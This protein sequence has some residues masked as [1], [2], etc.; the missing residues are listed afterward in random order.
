M[1]R[2][3]VTGIASLA[4]LFSHPV[5]SMNLDQMLVVADSDGNGAFVMANN[6]EQSY[7]I[8]S[9]VSELFTREDGS[10][11]RVEYDQ[12]NVEQWEVA[13]SNPK[14]VVESGRTRSIAVKAICGDQCDLSEDKTFEVALVPKPYVPEGEESNQT[15][16][17]F[18]GYS[19]VFIIP[20][21][22]PTF[23]V[24]VTPLDD[25][26]TIHNRSNT[27]VK[28]AIDNCQGEKSARCRGTYILVKGRAKTLPLPPQAV[29]KDLNVTIYDHSER[30]QKIMTVK[31]NG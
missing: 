7:F 16:T 19:A 8:E 17:V 29:G 24:E 3:I 31:S 28:V 30:H 2:T 6:K 14:M 9:G 18:I 13:V 15:V 12:S 4:L 10:L 27:M 22:Q 5:F 1:N 20:A 23:D 26:V 11:Y 25:M 21:S